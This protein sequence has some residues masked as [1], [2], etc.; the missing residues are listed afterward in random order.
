MT[1]HPGRAKYLAEVWNGLRQNPIDQ[2]MLI[3]CGG[4][5]KQVPTWIEHIRMPNKYGTRPDYAIAS[6]TDGD[7]VLLVDDDVAVKPGFVEDLYNGLISTRS[8]IVGI[9]GRTFHGSRYMGD[10]RWYGSRNIE[11]PVRVGFVGVIY[12]APREMFLFDTRGMQRNCDDIWWQMKCCPNAVKYVIPTKNFINIHPTC[13][14]S[15]AM[16]KTPVLKQQRQ[17]FYQAWYE[18]NYAPTGRIF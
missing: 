17:N 1:Y 14:D 9:I 7:Y 6:M 18:E 5:V 2:I 16:F 12:F 15:S 4:H 10:T 8:D 11:K 13:N 3:D